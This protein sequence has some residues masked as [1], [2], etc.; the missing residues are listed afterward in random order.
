MRMSIIVT[1]VDVSWKIP[2]PRLCHITLTL[3]PKI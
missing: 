1:A 2:V 3:L